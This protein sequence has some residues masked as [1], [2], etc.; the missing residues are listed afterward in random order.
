M[1]VEERAVAACGADV[2]MREKGL[3]RAEGCNDIAGDG[4]Q[5]LERLAYRLVVVDDINQEQTSPPDLSAARADD[6]RGWT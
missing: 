2:E 1:H 4:Q 5:R 3:G 6:V